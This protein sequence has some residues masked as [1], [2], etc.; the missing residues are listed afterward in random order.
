TATAAFD[1]V[2]SEVPS[3]LEDIHFAEIT[4]EKV[5]SLG[6]AEIEGI[7]RS[8]ANPVFRK[9]YALGCIGAVFGLNTYLAFVFLLIDKIRDR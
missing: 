5:S 1:T 6:P 3:L 4:K 8:F 9:L 2:L 7:V